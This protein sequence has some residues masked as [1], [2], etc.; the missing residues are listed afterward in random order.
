VQPD[1]KGQPLTRPTGVVGSASD[2]TGVEMDRP[3]CEVK[4][5]AQ[6][7]DL[8]ARIAAQDRL[9]KDAL[10]CSTNFFVWPAWSLDTGLTPAQE[11][12]VEHCSPQRILNDSR[13]LRRLVDSLR[14]PRHENVELDEALSI[15]AISYAR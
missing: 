6:I 10:P 9:A 11:K 12:F 3:T 7:R 2:L 13:S 1:T 8:L 4:V 5:D 14:H 15:F